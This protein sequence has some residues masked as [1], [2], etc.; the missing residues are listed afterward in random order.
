LKDGY[1]KLQE[2]YGKIIP[3]E[4]QQAFKKFQEVHDAEKMTHPELLKETK[5]LGDA[6]IKQLRENSKA[7]TQAYKES[8]AQKR[9]AQKK[10]EGR[11][12]EGRGM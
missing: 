3:K 11:E 6:M 1:K 4:K 7:T 2:Q 10:P 5:R 8:R 9:M 12:P